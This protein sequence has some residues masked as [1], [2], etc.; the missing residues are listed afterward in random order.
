MKGRRATLGIVV[1][2]TALF[3]LDAGAS[4]G[5]PDF[6]VADCYGCHDT[7]EKLHEKNKHAK[8]GCE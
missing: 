3:S 7:I 2:A 1:A 8:V 5:G 6:K 4:K